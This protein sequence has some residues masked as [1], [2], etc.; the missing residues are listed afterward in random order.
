MKE[1]FSGKEVAR[2]RFGEEAEVS[3]DLI[4][5]S[6]NFDIFVLTMHGGLMALSTKQ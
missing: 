5:C 6:E 2:F 1:L 3:I 4:Q